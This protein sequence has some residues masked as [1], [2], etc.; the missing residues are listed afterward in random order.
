M[1]KI[2][3]TPARDLSPHRKN[4]N[5]MNIVSDLMD[6]RSPLTSRRRYVSKT[7]SPLAIRKGSLP[8]NEEI[9]IFN[10]SRCG[11]EAFQN[12]SHNSLDSR[13]SEIPTSRGSPVVGLKKRVENFP[14]S[15]GCD[16]RRSSGASSIPEVIEECESEDEIDNEASNDSKDSIDYIRC[17]NCSRSKSTD[18]IDK[19]K[20]DQPQQTIIN[21]CYNCRHLMNN[22]QLPA[23]YEGR[24]SS[25]TAGEKLFPSPR[26]SRRSSLASSASELP[27]ISEPSFDEET[28]DTLE[29]QLSVKQEVEK[30]LKRNNTKNSLVKQGKNNNTDIREDI[31]SKIN[32]KSIMLSLRETK[33]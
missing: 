25:W 18:S 30:L 5:S 16:S 3:E 19:L 29:L 27:I 8:E 33:L 15:G 17:I 7:P 9:H 2:L 32:R 23:F 31:E 14:Y 22:T 28:N 6:V 12:R 26:N 11:L 21:Y 24:R 1:T 10:D 20:L 4:I 13:L